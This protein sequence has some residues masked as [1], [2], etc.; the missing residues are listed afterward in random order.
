M[1]PYVLEIIDQLED[2]T[3]FEFGCYD[4]ADTHELARNGFRNFYT[5]EADP[6]NLERIRKTGLPNGVQLVPKAIGRTEGK[7]LLYQST[8]M[9][10]GHGIWTGSSSIK[11]PLVQK[12]E[13]LSFDS[14]V[15]V[16]VVSLD[17]FCEEEGIEKIDLIWAD[18]QGAEVDLV[19]GGKRMLQNTHYLF[20]EHEKIQTY[21]G[22][23]NFDQMMASL[24]GWNLIEKFP[25]DV[26]LENTRWQNTKA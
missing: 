22:Q 15:E 5:F 7:T 8:N 20:M 12:S 9:I 11:K 21:E 26:L 6:R 24:P 14:A 2:A 1:N 4:G 25:N 19:A 13:N 10:S 3:I 16:E 17:R 18:I 23:W